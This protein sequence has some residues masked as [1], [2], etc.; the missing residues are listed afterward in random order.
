MGK[1]ILR[2]CE[3]SDVNLKVAYLRY[4]NPVGADESG[5]IR[6]NPQGTPNNLMPYIT[7]VA[8]GKGQYY[9]FMVGIGQLMMELV[10]VTI[11]M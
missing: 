11:F 2:G 4:F 10:F 5:L 8:I 6:D 9:L 1:Q 7:Q 3:A